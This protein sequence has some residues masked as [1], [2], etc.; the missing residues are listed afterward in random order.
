[1]KKIFKR[2]SRFGLRTLLA[3]FLILALVFG[4]LSNVK[5]DRDREVANVNKLTLSNQPEVWAQ[6]YKTIRRNE[7]ASGA[8][9][10]LGAS[11]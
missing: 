9:E 7:T 1:M 3:L 8:M 4:W 5:S 2:I 11:M 10:F 6:G